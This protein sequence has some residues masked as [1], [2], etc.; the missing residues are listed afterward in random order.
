[1]NLVDK[2]LVSMRCDD[3]WTYSPSTYV[4]SFVK[5]LGLVAAYCGCEK[6]ALINCLCSSSPV[7]LA[8]AYECIGNCHGF[9]V[10]DSE[11]LDLTEDEVKQ[12]YGG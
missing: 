3:A 6:A 2:V 4:E 10:F 5:D 7:K 8:F 12:R 1:M 9:R 11:P